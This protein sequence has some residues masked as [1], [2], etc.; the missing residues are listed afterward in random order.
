MPATTTINAQD[1][2]DELKPLGSESYVNILRKHG[3]N[4]PCYGVKIEYLKKIQKRVKTNYQ[5]ALD[6]FDT[7]VYDAMY[8]AGLMADESKMTK[9]DLIKWVNN[10][11]SAMLCGYTVAWVASDAEC[12][13]RGLRYDRVAERSGFIVYRKLLG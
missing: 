1:I 9:K 3:I 7:G 10:A 4:G 5:L 6:L 2:L 11:G 8:L 12:R 13:T